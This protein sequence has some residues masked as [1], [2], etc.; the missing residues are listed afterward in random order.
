M[1]GVVSVHIDGCEKGGPGLTFRLV[2]RLS[3]EVDKEKFCV[4][5]VW[6]VC[7]PRRP[8]TFFRNMRGSDSFSELLHKFSWKDTRGCSFSGDSVRAAMTNMQG[9]AAQVGVRMEVDA[10]F[11]GLAKRRQRRR[12][13]EL[14]PPPPAPVRRLFDCVGMA[15]PSKESGLC[16]WG[17]L[18][19]L[20]TFPK[21]MSSLLGAS[22]RDERLESMLHRSIR[23]NSAAEKLRRHIFYAHGI[24]DDPSVAPQEEGQNGFGELSRLF[25]V[26]GVGHDVLSAPSLTPLQEADAPRFVGVRVQRSAWEAPLTLRHRKRTWHLCGGFLGSEYCEHQTCLARLGTSNLF[27]FYDADAV[28]LGVGPTFFRVEDAAKWTSNLEVCI[29]YSNHTEES[30]FCEFNPSNPHP[31]KVSSQNLVASGGKRIDP[32]HMGGQRLLNAEWIYC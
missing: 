6:K 13:G 1:R 28:R 22:F 8:P 27:A 7:S 20:C 25:G 31:L 19:F 32:K 18:L 23:S 5:G 4:D 3:D 15:Q 24:G 26:L 10:F 11:H 14:P 12:T 29:P 9:N 17:S 2:N 30:R 21:K 16:W